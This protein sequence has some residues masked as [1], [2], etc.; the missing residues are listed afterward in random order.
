MCQIPKVVIVAP[1]E[2]HQELRRALSSLEYDIAAT[3]TTA[4]DA[5]G[6]TA[7]VAIAWEPD[8]EM[9][10]RLRELTLKTVAVGGD[11]ASA[12]MTL[13]PDEIASFKSRIWE[14][15]RPA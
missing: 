15:F 10:L 13:A 4:D 7:D 14:L 12:D 5:S 3:V 9:L 6:I 11:G 2:K 8:E 1:P